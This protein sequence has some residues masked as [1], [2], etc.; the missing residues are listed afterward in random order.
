MIHPAAGNLKTHLVLVDEAIAGPDLSDRE[1]Q[2]FERLRRGLGRKAIARELG[3]TPGSV[4]GY[5]R[6]M[7]RKLGF[8]HSNGM[9]NESRF[10]QPHPPSPTTIS[11]QA[12]PTLP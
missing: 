4:A 9:E 6:S 2:V 8:L 12:N 1:R 11:L 10:R 5:S 3:V 7:C